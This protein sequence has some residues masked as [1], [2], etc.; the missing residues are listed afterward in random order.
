M[1]YPIYYPL[2]LLLLLLASCND[3]TFDPP[4]PE[5]WV[6]LNFRV[7]RPTIGTRGGVDS[8]AVGVV[9][10]FEGTTLFLLTKS[11]GSI[12]QVVTAPA[13]QVLYPS[14]PGLEMKFNR[15]IVTE[16]HVIGNVEKNQLHLNGF[17]INPSS[18]ATALSGKK[19]GDIQYAIANQGVN[20][21]PTSTA[22]ERLDPRQ[23]NVSGKIKTASLNVAMGYAIIAVRPAISR[24]EIS[25]LVPKDNADDKSVEK[26]RLDSIYIN[27]TFHKMGVDYT[28]Y[29]SVKADSVKY[30][31][32][33]A[34]FDDTAYPKE[35]SIEVNK[36]SETGTNPPLA[37]PLKSNE[38]QHWSF[39]VPPAQNPNPN[40]DP[41]KPFH[42]ENFR[43]IG[44]IIAP[45]EGGNTT[46]T[47]PYSAIPLIICKLSDIKPEPE[48]KD[49]AGYSWLTVTRFINLQNRKDTIQCLLPGM[50]Y[51]LE[52]LVFSSDDLHSQPITESEAGIAALVRI[53]DWTEV[54]IPDPPIFPG[55]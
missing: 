14:G 48:W 13:E 38:K 5:D 45:Y 47:K 44:N 15:A 39:Y 34:V 46:N 54:K 35:F 50:V 8:T 9:P 11:D 30:Y 26:Y 49:E 20:P 23:V 55:R 33:D 52:Q 6:E 1:K 3:T 19:L 43:Y 21:G 42:P 2:L 17:S 51:Q 32:N 53:V 27:N 28:T 24:I 37:P 16:I 12:H 4:V 22:D 41:S 7:E 29:P 25:S 10:H 18:W 31:W 36:E 40:Y